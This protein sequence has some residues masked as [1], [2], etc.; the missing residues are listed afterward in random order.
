MELIIFL[1]GVKMGNEYLVIINGD[2]ERSI[3]FDDSD[4]LYVYHEKTYDVSR[5]KFHKF[6][7][8]L[9][10]D[11]D[12]FKKINDDFIVVDI[13]EKTAAIAHSNK[14]NILGRSFND[15]FPVYSR[16]GFT[17]L[18]DE[19]HKN[20]S[21]IEFKTLF[22]ENGKI[23]KV[24]KHKIFQ[25]N[26]YIFNSILDI[27]NQEYIMQLGDKLFASDLIGVYETNEKGDIVRCNNKLCD[28]IG[29][30]PEEFKK[31]K[32]DSLIKEYENDD[33][34]II[35]YEDCVNKFLE[36]EI[37]VCHATIKVLTKEG[38][39]KWL[40]IN[41]TCIYFVDNMIIQTI[42]LDITENKFKELSIHD[43]QRDITILEKFTKTTILSL[44]SDGLEYTPQLLE[45]IELD[46]EE[47]HHLDLLK[48]IVDEDRGELIRLLNNISEE[49][50]HFEY[51]GRIKT[52]KGNI[53]YLSIYFKH[54]YDSKTVSKDIQIVNYG[55]I[56]FKRASNFI[57]TIVFIQD[58]TDREIKEKYLEELTEQLSNKNFE[59][60]VLLKEIHHRVKNNLQLL[61]S[62]LNLEE[63]FNKDNPQEII[64]NIKARIQNISF[65][66]E[67]TYL[68]NDLITI[69]L[70]DFAEEEIINLLRLYDEEENIKYDV[71]IQE[72]ILLPMDFV[73]TL[74]LMGNEILTNSIKY[75]FPEDQKDKHIFLHAYM[76]DK[77]HLIIICG[78]NGRGFSKSMDI[79]SSP[80]LGLTII[81]NLTNQLD[82]KV[83]PYDC[84]GV[85]YYFEFDL[86]NI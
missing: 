63:H 52:Y 7:T 2:I 79:Y 41:S 11:V 34:S 19:V 64:E 30:S 77:N 73:T 44:T 71:E 10:V 17:D 18:F 13:S 81:N 59:K 49:N 74:S 69:N 14:N 42:V 28:I 43:F 72:D 29:Y 12:V 58:V 32:M 76:D 60:E 84:E 82:G 80:S 8:E 24:F 68:S 35:S 78:D 3:S 47:N 51:L 50:S 75:A 70:K 4:D 21:V 15:I 62:F 22:F 5:F 57:R 86:N 61:L 26:G 16:F 54:I 39:Y 20:D 27:T 53:K 38:K 36:K 31:Y 65:A 48:L 45:I 33:S 56:D 23:F 66:H 6:L 9:P 83:K 67:K 37:L 55:G 46:E 40:R 1:W 85:G 25:D